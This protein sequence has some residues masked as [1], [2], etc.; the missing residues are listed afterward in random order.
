MPRGHT[1]L[2]WNVL[3]VTA[4]C[5]TGFASM[6]AIWSKAHG[7]GVALVAAFVLLAIVVHVARSGD[8]PEKRS[9]S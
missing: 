5:W 3:M 4:I 7:Y 6:Y 2:V 8:T 9:G 1:R